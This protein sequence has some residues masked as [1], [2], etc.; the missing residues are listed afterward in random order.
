MISLPHIKIYSKHIEWRKQK[1]IRLNE[2]LDVYQ[3]GDFMSFSL[4]E[5]RAVVREVSKRHKKA[6]KKEKEDI[7]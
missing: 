3:R 6:K 5:R 7:R 1:K 4:K 2:I